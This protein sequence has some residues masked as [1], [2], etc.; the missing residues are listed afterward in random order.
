MWTLN[1]YSGKC[2]SLHLA[3]TLQLKKKIKKVF[4]ALKSQFVDQLD[5][6]KMTE[7]LQ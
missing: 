7:A 2:T 3:R 1:G 5:I 4:E 6:A